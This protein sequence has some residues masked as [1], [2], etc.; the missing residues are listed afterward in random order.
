MRSF[1]LSAV[2]TALAMLWSAAVYAQSAPAVPN[3]SFET[4]EARN[5]QREAP[6]SWLALEDLLE[7]ANNIPSLPALGFTIKSSTARQGALA[8]E[9]RTLSVQNQTFPGILVL[10]SR[11]GIG[12][13]YTARPGQLQ[14]WYRLTGA[15]A[16][17]DSAYVGAL[18]TRNVAGT[19]TVVGGQ[20]VVLQP[21]ANYTLVTVPLIYSPQST[22]APDSLIVEI[23][24]GLADVIHPGT[25]LLIDD[26]QLTGAI[27]SA[28]EVAGPAALQVYP[29]PSATGEFSLATPTG[30]GISTAPL[31]VLDAAGRVVL[32]QGAAPPSAAQ[33]RLIDLRA[34]RPGVYVLR[35]DTPDG[36]VRRKLVIP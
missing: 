28:A 34:Q 25:V 23:W 31:T 30:S 24:S 3:G 11:T 6:R 7:L 26:V 21:A 22:L 20:A 14:F 32:R 35:L 2:C 36:P 4:W 19:T 17:V 5:A 27:T 18:L 13:P 9:L 8:A 15:Q 10:G 33:G 16:A 12:V 29:N 1:T